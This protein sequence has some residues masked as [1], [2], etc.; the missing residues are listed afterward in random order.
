MGLGL[1]K[2]TQ[3]L[4]DLDKKAEELDTVLR[5][6]RVEINNVF[7]DLMGLKKGKDWKKDEYKF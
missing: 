3:K 6:V 7:W 2:L 1:G 4:I 5:N